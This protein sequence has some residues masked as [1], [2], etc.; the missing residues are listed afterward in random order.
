MGSCEV[1]YVVR[2]ARSRPEYVKPSIAYILLRYSD[3][4]HVPLCVRRRSVG[5]SVGQL[6]LSAQPWSRP[7]LYM[8]MYMCLLW[9]SGTLRRRRS[10]NFEASL[11][12]ESGYRRLGLS[13]PDPDRRRA[14]MRHSPP[15]PASASSEPVEGGSVTA[16]PYARKGVRAVNRRPRR[17]SSSQQPDAAADI[18]DLHRALVT[19]Q[20]PHAGTYAHMHMGSGSEHVSPHPLPSRRRA[21]P[22]HASCIMQHATCRCIRSRARARRR[23]RNHRCV[24]GARKRSDS[25]G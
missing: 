21:S 15:L 7:N 2:I 16:M 23:G 25:D 18:A 5:R 14:A 19:C 12:V 8:Y 6:P 11:V 20:C 22:H 9:H 4:Y 17:P 24:H 3:M 1:K 10:L 13:E